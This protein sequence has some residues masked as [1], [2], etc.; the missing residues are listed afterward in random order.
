MYKDKNQLEKLGQKKFFGCIKYR[1]HWS[2]TVKGWGVILAIALILL[3]FVF[4]HIHSFLAVSQPIANAD[5]LVVEGWIDDEPV[6]G[7]LAEF[8]RGNYQWL[9]ATGTPVA[10][11]YFLSKYKSFAEICAATLMSMGADKT[12]L[13]AVS[14]PPTKRDRTLAAAIALRE[15]LSQSQLS[16]KSINLYSYNVHTRRS[17]LLFRRA[18]PPEIQLGAIAH[19]SVVY[20]PKRWFTSSEGIRTVLSEFIGYVYAKLISWQG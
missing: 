1:S 6:A 5:M 4:A 20:D 13:I 10:R 11:G 9:V 12:K 17:W 16:I 15:W 8:K 3:S 18:L 7:A 2:L 14:A 19:P